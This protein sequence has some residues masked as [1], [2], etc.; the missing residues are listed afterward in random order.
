MAIFKKTEENQ[1]PEPAA[2]PRIAPTSQVTTRNVSVIG[3]T[4]VF[5]GELSADEDLIIEGQIE[6]TIAHHKKNLT[7][8]KHGRVKADIH[9]SSVVVLGQLIGD[10]H[11]DGLVSLSK[12]ADVRGNIFCTNIIME[13][14]A[15]FSGMIDMGDAAIVPEILKEPGKHDTIRLEKTQQAASHSAKT[16]SY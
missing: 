10:I 1:T 7:V 4:L 12:G 6:G 13:N 9:A 2:A 3:A 8:G 11:S 15:R 14:G 5:K 16:N